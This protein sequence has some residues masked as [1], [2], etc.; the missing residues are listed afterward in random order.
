MEATAHR[1]WKPEDLLNLSDI[2]RALGVT[3]QTAQKWHRA[4]AGS[5]HSKSEFPLRS[6]AVAMGIE[7]SDPPDAKSPQYPW[8]VVKAF[9]MAIGYLDA[10]GNPVPEMKIK[11]KGR[12]S[13]VAPT[14]DPRE[15][16]PLRYYKNHATELLGLKAETV[17]GLRAK[18]YFPPEDGFDEIAR[19]FWWAETLQARMNQV[20]DR[21]EKRGPRPDGYLENGQPFWHAGPN[22][23]WTRRWHE[24]QEKSTS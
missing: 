9:G 16:N 21:R 13:P 17:S 14:V 11:G 7:L 6:V 12:W 5:A 20:E 2:G 8:K 23:F 10:E 15:G 3:R 24:N 4:P 22:N 1:G 18:H 19:P